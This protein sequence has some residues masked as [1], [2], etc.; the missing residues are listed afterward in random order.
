M[1]LLLKKQ[2]HTQS[3]SLLILPPF[4]QALGTTALFSVSI[5]VHILDL[6]GR[7]ILRYA[8]F[9]RGCFTQHAVIYHHFIPFYDQVRYHCMATAPPLYLIHSSLDGHLDCIHSLTI[10]NDTAVTTCVQVSVWKYAVISLR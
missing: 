6:P 7:L 3:Q 5:Y 4:S 2:H 1:L 8:A 10:M 9:L